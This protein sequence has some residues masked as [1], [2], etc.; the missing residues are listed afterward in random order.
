MHILYFR[1]AVVVV[2]EVLMGIHNTCTYTPVGNALP[3]ELI[4]DTRSIT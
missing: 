4:Y 3:I 1:G 2:R